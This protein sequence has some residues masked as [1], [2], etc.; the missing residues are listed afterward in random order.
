MSTGSESRA[1][2]F[3]QDKG[4]EYPEASVGMNFTEGSSLT[5]TFK[6]NLSSSHWSKVKVDIFSLIAKKCLC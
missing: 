3:K 2:D 4:Y 6:A 5:R 1:S